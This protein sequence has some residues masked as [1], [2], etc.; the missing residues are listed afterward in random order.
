MTFLA[1]F[2]SSRVDVE[3]VVVV[4]VLVVVLAPVLL[5][6]LAPVVVLVPVVMLVPVVVLADEEVA[7]WVVVVDV[8]AVGVEVVVEPVV[9]VLAL[10]SASIA[11]SRLSVWLFIKDS[12]LFTFLIFVS[13]CYFFYLC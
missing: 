13:P 9:A 3:V 12:N 11:A 8:V 10:L 7:G 2:S 4:P 5:V 1:F 6:V